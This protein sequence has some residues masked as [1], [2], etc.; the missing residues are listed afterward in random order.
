[1][2][3]R[4]C[5]LVAVPMALIFGVL[6]TTPAFA[7]DTIDVANTGQILANGA[8]VT[9]Q[10]TVTCSPQFPGD[11]VSVRLT[12]TQAVKHNQIT[13]A[14]SGLIFGV[15]CDDQP[16]ILALTLVPSPL[17]IYRVDRSRDHPPSG[18]G[19]RDRRLRRVAR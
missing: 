15:P 17:A 13:S 19:R 16:H 10:V 11:N 4:R 1:M 14:D 2:K 8:A 7:I 5:A 18:R 12:L 3:L 6:V 9:T